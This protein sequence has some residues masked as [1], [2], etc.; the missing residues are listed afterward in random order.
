MSISVSKELLQQIIGEYSIDDAITEINELLRYDY[1][2]TNEHSKEVRLILKASFDTRR[3][4]VIKFKNEDD[5]TPALIEQQ[6]QFSQHLLHAG[7]ATPR[8]YT[9]NNQFVLTQSICDYDVWITVE[10]FVDGEIKLVTPEISYKTGILL[11]KTHTISERDHCHVN[12]PVLFDP[13]TANDLFSY[14]AFLSYQDAFDGENRVCF[15]RIQDKYHDHMHSL[16]GI[17]SRPQYAVQGDISDCN[18]YMASSGDIGL[19][20]YNRC[21]DSILFCDAAMQG[22][23]QAR[24]M[25]YP[26]DA[27]ERYAD[28]LFSD[29]LTGYNSIRPFSPEELNAIPILY[30]VASAFWKFQLIFDDDSM[31]HLIEKDDKNGITGLLHRIEKQITHPKAITR[32][33]QTIN[34]G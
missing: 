8:F 34:I 22:I 25:D 28:R 26:C 23:F 5:V 17:E 19:F 10:E 4:V 20:D 9:A 24:L 6:T 13:F 33:N 3:P 32:Q 16:A 27:T 30:A 11:A 14:E 29:F 7:I 2:K 1:Q 31:K 21:G 15:E 18:L 12:S